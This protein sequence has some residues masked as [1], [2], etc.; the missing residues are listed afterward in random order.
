MCLQ[1]IYVT[2]PLIGQALP[3]STERIHFLSNSGLLCREPPLPTGWHMKCTPPTPERFSCLSLC[4][5]LVR[6]SDSGCLLQPGDGGFCSPFCAVL[7]KTVR[8]PLHRECLSTPRLLWHYV[9]F[10]YSCPPARD[11][12]NPER[13]CC[14]TGGSEEPALGTQSLHC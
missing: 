11:R 14:G 3:I 10:S 2:C 13:F 1:K 4:W 8:L 6:V 9:S 12:G 7:T 5:C